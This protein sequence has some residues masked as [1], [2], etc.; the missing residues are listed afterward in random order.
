MAN[1]VQF[2]VDDTSPSISYLPFGDTLSLP[3]RS[4]GWNPFFSESG[5]AG[6]QGVTGNGTSLHVTSHDGA[7][8]IVN[9]QGE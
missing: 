8:L 2:V 4:A 5:F 1:I 9:W 6:A 3:D 7:T